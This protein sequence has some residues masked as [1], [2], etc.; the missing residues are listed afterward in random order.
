MRLNTG[1]GR[2]SAKG[3]FWELRKAS[4]KPPVVTLVEMVI[5]VC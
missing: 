4:T 2:S 1:K 5:C 3:K